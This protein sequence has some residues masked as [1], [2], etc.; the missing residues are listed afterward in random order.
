M[1]VSDYRNVALIIQQ[2]NVFLRR[3]LL[4]L[5][6]HLIPLLV[7]QHLLIILIHFAKA[8]LPVLQLVDLWIALLH[9]TSWDRFALAL[10]LHHPVIKGVNSGVGARLDAPGGGRHPLGALL[11]HL[12]A[13]HFVDDLP[14]DAV[15]L[16][17]LLFEDVDV[18]VDV[19][20]LVLLLGAVAVV[21]GPHEVGFLTLRVLLSHIVLLVF[22]LGLII[23]L[24][25]ARIRLHLVLVLT[26]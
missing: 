1:K 16:V 4:A 23:L 11:R 14:R 13:L 20:K 9:H 3:F 10:R 19:Q 26:E 17:V 12:G 5:L 15:A 6:L 24:H 21:A 2:V 18:V 8:V 22:F 25:K 7:V